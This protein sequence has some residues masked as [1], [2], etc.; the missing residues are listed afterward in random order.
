MDA[1]EVEGLSK[2]FGSLDAVENLSFVIPTGK[3][4]GFL[5]PNGAGKTTTLRMILGLVRPNAGVARVLGRPFTDLDDPARA[6]GAL[7]DTEQFHPQRTA[8]NHLKVMAR[9]ARTDDGR[10]DEVLDLVDLSDAAE[11]K[12][13]GYSLGMKQRLGLAGALLGDPQILVL[14][15]PANGL[16]PSGIRWL[17]NFLRTYVSTGRAVL[18]SSHLLAEISEMADDVVVINRGRL[19]THAPVHQL[20]ARAAGARTVTPDSERLSHELTQRGIDHER[21]SL[22]TLHVDAAAEVVGAIA[23]EAGIPIYGL[24][25]AETNLEDVFFELT[26]QQRSLT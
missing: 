25:N 6:I 12:V 18:V 22:D 5:G 26:E 13:G 19:V 1:I 17:R 11:R 8:R 24:E 15:E 3:V 14:D 4:T 16:D 10:I 21:L 20:V 2:R 23:A 7:L 9:A